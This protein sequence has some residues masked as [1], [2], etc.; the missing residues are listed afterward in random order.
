MNSTTPTIT[1]DVDLTNPGQFLACCGLLELAGRVDSGAIGWF[2]D[3][4]F[5]VSGGGSQLLE[6][7]IRCK[8]TAILPRDAHDGS[9][10][11][12]ESSNEKEPKSPPVLLGEPFSLR[13]DWWED[14]AAAEAGFKTWSAGMTIPGF[15][16][17]TTTGKGKRRKRGPSMRDHVARHLPAD[18][19]L[20]QEAEAIEKPSL[21][22]F[23]SRI[24]RNTAIDLGFLGKVTFAFSPAVEL[25]ALVGLQ[26]FRPR[27]VVRWERNV[28]HAWSEPLP[29]ATAAAVTHGLVPALSCGTYSFSVK[30]RDAQGR[31]KAFGPAVLERS[32]IHV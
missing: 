14:E 21:F 24:S 12:S 13:L 5:H 2:D 26:R 8:V 31:Y 10:G 19:G 9:N 27:V 22:N 11:E 30:P 18:R 28:Y 15:F 6:R 20:F 3:R 7:L 4:Q 23:D 1:L 25:L 29:V 16:N 32:S 17:G